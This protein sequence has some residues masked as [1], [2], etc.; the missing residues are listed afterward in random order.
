[1]CIPC[2][3]KATGGGRFPAGAEWT[4]HPKL[5]SSLPAGNLKSVHRT[6][7]KYQSSPGPCTPP[8]ASTTISNSCGWAPALS[9]LL[10]YS[11]CSIAAGLDMA[12]T[13]SGAA[14]DEAGFWGRHDSVFLYVPNLIGE[15]EVARSL[16]QCVSSARAAAAAAAAA[17]AAAPTEPKHLTLRCTCRLRA[18]GSSCLCVCGGTA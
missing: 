10:Q 3:I 9:A 16:L 13:R 5:R 18:R 7:P 11:V 15:R 17:T 14:K 4:L 8:A 12:R 2:T 6:S 1:M